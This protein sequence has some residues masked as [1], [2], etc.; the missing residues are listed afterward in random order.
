MSK[1]ISTRLPT[2]YLKRQR[3]YVVNALRQL[4]ADEY[5]MLLPETH[6]LPQLLEDGEVLLGA[7]FG[8]Y[9]KDMGAHKGRGL[10]VITDRRVLFIDKKPLFLHFDDIKLDMVS[11]I[12]YGKI[13]LS[14]TITLHTRV[15]DIWIRTFNDACARKFVRA[16]E[17]VLFHTQ[18]EPE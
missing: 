10:L 3:A 11:G 6:Y 7:V 9:T 13:G 1:T 18:G 8:K 16:V 14:E 5:N 17:D 15:D 4:G 12:D 2:T